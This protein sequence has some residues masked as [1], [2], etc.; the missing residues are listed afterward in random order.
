VAEV[1]EISKNAAKREWPE[2]VKSPATG[3]RKRG[4]MRL[5]WASQ[6]RERN[7]FRQPG[8]IMFKDMNKSGGK[9][10]RGGIIVPTTSGT[11]DGGGG[12]HPP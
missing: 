5:P 12:V 7:L 6:E 8:R 10:S 9:T 2:G 11:I 3:A 1:R 4:P